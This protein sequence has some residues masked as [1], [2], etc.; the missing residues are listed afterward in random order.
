MPVD[1]RVPVTI[2]E[3]QHVEPLRR[4]G[5]PNGLA[6]AMDDPLQVR[7]LVG[8]KSALTC[9]QCRRGATSV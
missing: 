7:I 5:S 1:V 4:D 8:G 6:D 3:R 2:P 9:S